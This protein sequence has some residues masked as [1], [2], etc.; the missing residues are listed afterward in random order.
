MNT[1]TYHALYNI[2][3]VCNPSKTL[4]DSHAHTSLAYLMPRPR[5]NAQTIIQTLE[6]CTVRGSH[7]F[8]FHPVVE[9]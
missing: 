3:N 9:K 7:G 5:R 8:I 2:T 4:H 1:L 6:P